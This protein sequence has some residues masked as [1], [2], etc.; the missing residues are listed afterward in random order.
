MSASVIE[1]ILAR[2]QAA[3]VAVGATA[4]GARVYRGRTDAFA[5]DE[6][7]ALNLRRTNSDHVPLGAN[8]SSI[9]A[10][11]DVDCHVDGSADWETAA[12][13]LHMQVHGVLTADAALA[14]LGRGL[15]CTGTDAEGDRADRVVGKLTARYQMQAFVR[16][17]DLTRAIT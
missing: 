1:Q 12:D 17:G 14:L 6:H 5:D 3:L 15:R 8:G 4:A 11:W 16:P 2:A 13:A 10:A 7:P 9:L